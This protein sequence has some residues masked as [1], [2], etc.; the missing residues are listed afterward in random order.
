MINPIMEENTQRIRDFLKVVKRMKEPAIIF[1]N[2]D[3]KSVVSKEIKKAFPGVKHAL[4]S[5]AITDRDEIDRIFSG[6]LKE[7]SILQVQI[8]KTTDPIVMRRL[9]Q[10]LEDG[11]I[12]VKTGSNWFK[13]EPTETWQAIVWVNRKDINENDFQLELLF[14]HKLVVE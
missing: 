12:P 7:G 2:N 5:S 3:L 6:S 1:T 9:E 14:T 11:N 8:D 4:L 10:L 13:V